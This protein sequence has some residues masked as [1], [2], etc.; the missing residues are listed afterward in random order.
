[1]KEDLIAQT[2]LDQMVGSDEM[3]MLKAAIPYLPA[4]GQQVISLY[5][6][7]SE[8]ANTAKLF[9]P[10]NNSM[11]ICASSSGTAPLE[12]LNDIRQFCY[13]K[14]RRQLD[15]IVNAFAMMEMIQVM[16]QE[17]SLEGGNTHE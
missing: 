6:K 13:G 1:M 16:Q 5:T 3:Q 9:S 15:Q 10:K 14:S 12:M 11:Q 17:P 7:I 2:T 4:K 8:L